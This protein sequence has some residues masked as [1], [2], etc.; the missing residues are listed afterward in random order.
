VVLG[1]GSFLN[2]QEPISALPDASA[3]TGA[4]LVPVVQAGQTR[5][6]TTAAIAAGPSIAALPFVTWGAS[7]LGNALQ[8]QGSSD[9]TLTSGGGSISPSLTTTVSAGTTVNTGTQIPV[10]TYDS[11]GR[12]TGVSSVAVVGGGG[13]G[14]QTTSGTTDRITVTNGSTNPVVDIASTYAGQATIATLGTITTGTWNAGVVA[15][16]YGGTGINNAGKTITLGGNF[17]TS[18][19]FATTLTVSGATNVTLPTTGTLSTLAGAEALTNKS[20]NG[21]TLTT[22]GSSTQFLDG[23]GAY[24]TPAGS[25]GDVVGPASSTNTALARFNGTT[26]KLIQNSGVT[27]DGSNNV[28]GVT[29]LATGPIT[30][31]SASATALAVGP[32]GTTNPALQVDCSTA[33][34]ATGVTITSAAAGGTVILQ[35]S[36]SGTDEGMII[37]GKGTGQLSLDTS[38]TNGVVALRTAATNRV[39]CT[40]STLTFTP[41]S[42]T[43]A[44]NTHFLYT[45][46]ADTGLTAG[47]ES[48]SVFFDMG[49]TRQHN[50]NTAITTQRDFVVTPSTH[51]FSAAGGVIT[52]AY[53]FAV[54]AAPAAGTNATITRTWACY[55]GANVRQIGK[56]VLDATLTAAGTTG[57][58]TINKPA[59]SVNFAAAATSLVVTNS[60]VTTSSIVLVTVM[61]ND[62]TM[63][64][65]QVVVAAGSFTLYPNEAP[66]AETK[67]GFIVYN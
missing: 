4:E 35:T 48:I 27:V 42:T 46:A 60:F 54:T 61:T 45:G 31:T 52:D 28:A 10:L 64:S 47:S 63:T 20:V 29:S 55:F 38:S 2:S 50:S 18:G 57:A 22:G 1:Y 30:L 21:V 12:I 56:T 34:A 19:A 62:T 13:G 41:G 17:A 24:S 11:K 67:V 49:Q 9:I 37:R 36:S 40:S 3:L 51:S 7:S 33:S 14:G 59:G 43:T 66:T 44:S 39:R 23:T 15:G 26:G 5:K 32:N 16:Q 65:C 58:Q 25:S 8:L 53:G 6:T